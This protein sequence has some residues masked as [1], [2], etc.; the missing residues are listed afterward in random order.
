M[1]GASGETTSPPKGAQ[2][3]SSLEGPARQV[4]CSSCVRILIVEEE[5]RLDDK[6]AG[7]DAGADDYLTKPF[8]FE[9]LLAR[10]RALLRRRP[11]EPVDVLAIAD[12]A[13]DRTSRQVQRGGREI[14]LTPVAR[15]R[16]KLEAGDA[17]RL[18]HSV[19]GMGYVLRSSERGELDGTTGAAG[20]G[21]RR[22]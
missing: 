6:I 9:E 3:A 7:L 15:L 5:Y 14:E 11:A 16:R 2:A 17:P 19:P 18:L 8:A 22:P 21:D 10:I 4:G 13:L 12:L 20:P 1:T